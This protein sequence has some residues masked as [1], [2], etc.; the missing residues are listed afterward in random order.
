MH[1]KTKHTSKRVQGQNQSQFQYAM[2][3]SSLSCQQIWIWYSH[4]TG[5]AH[6]LAKP[7]LGLGVALL[8]ECVF[9][10]R[11]AWEESCRL[12][13][14]STVEL[15]KKIHFSFR[16]C[17]DRQSK[18]ELTYFPKQRPWSSVSSSS[19]SSDPRIL[20]YFVLRGFL[21]FQNDRF[22]AFVA[23]W[24]F[25]Q[26]TQRTVDIL[27]ALNCSFFSLTL[28]FIYHPST[29]RYGGIDVA[30][31]V[32]EGRNYHIFSFLS[33]DQGSTKTRGQVHSSEIA[34]FR[35]YIWSYSE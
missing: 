28:P 16:S 10:K 29:V 17:Q 14:E 30:K 12:M 21:R 7:Q 1:S 18:F 3:N 34:G 26:S 32:K 11:S 15:N 4:Q 5:R 24:V 33:G 19:L 13:C 23:Q 25:G 31:G 27:F 8:I 35:K 2:P 22:S 9:N 20:W 6:P